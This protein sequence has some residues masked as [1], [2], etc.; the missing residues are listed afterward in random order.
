MG[1]ATY[2]IPITYDLQESNPIL[3]ECYDSPCFQVILK[4]NFGS[5]RRRKY[6]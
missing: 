1:V 6:K 5:K 4:S 2:P 3:V